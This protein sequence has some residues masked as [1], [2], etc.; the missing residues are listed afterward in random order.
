MPPL[1]DIPSPCCLPLRDPDLLRSQAYVDGAWIKA[2][3]GDHVPVYNPA[4][5]QLISHVPCLGAA[6][7]KRAVLAA[8]SSLPQA[9]DPIQPRSEPSC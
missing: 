6:E 9:G 1:S 7:T 3:Q 8:A 2:D 4:D 5:D